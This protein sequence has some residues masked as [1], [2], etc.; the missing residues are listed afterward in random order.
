MFKLMLTSIAGFLISYGGYCLAQGPAPGKSESSAIM[1]DTTVKQYCVT[2]HNDT[3]KTAGLTLQQVDPY[4]IS[5]DGKIWEMVLRK[6]R[7]RTMPPAGMPRPDIATYDEVA[8]YL[9]TTLDRYAE[10]YP[11]PGRPSLRRLNRN[12]YLNA[13]RDLLAVKIND[14]T[15]LPSDDTMY[16]F[17]NVGAVLTLSPLLAEQYIT[18]AR[19]VRRQ[20]LGEPEMQPEFHSYTVPRYLM[21]ADWIGEDMPMGSR[22]GLALT[23]YFPMDG[24]YVVQIRLQRNSRDYIRG[25]LG[26]PHQI[27]IS[28]DKHK[29]GSMTVGG[30]KRGPSSGILSSATQGDPVQEA[31]E[32]HADEDLEIRFHAKAGTRQLVVTFPKRNVVAEEPL[33]TMQ[34]IVDYA[35]YKAGVPGIDIVTVG[36]PYNPQISH[37]SASRQKIFVCKPADQNDQAC[38]SQIISSLARR[39]YRRTLSDTEITGLMGFFRQGQQQGGFDEGIGHAIERILAG[40]RFLFVTEYV[41]ENTGAGELYRIPDV[42]LA[43]RLSLFLWSS[44]PDEELLALAESGQLANPEM[45]ANQVKRMLDDPRSRTLVDNFAS[46][47]LTLN[48]LNVAAPDNEIFP[49]FDDNLR[50]DMRRETVHFFEYIFRNNRPILELLDADYTFMNERLAQHYGIPDIYGNH[51]RKVTLGGE[52][53]GGLLGHGSILTVTSYANRTSPVTR[54]KWI[55]ENVL[56]APP[57]PPPAFVPG[58]REKND[59]GAVLSMRQ[60]MEQ[61][62]ANPVCASCHKVMDPLGFALENYDA[63]GRWRT[64]DAASGSPIDS[65][66]ALPD[67]TTFEGPVELRMTLSQKRQDDFVMTVVEK[68]LTY[69]LGR[70]IEYTDLPAIRSIMKDTESD[71]YRFS[72]LIM[73]VANSKPFQMRRAPGH[74]DI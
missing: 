62:R 37:D 15:I 16:G 71:D 59:E 42:E 64:V 45:L 1:L 5:A 20:A 11:Q 13:V 53:R 17:D 2:C 9:E 48:R 47:W 52:T 22:G 21:Q 32:R 14:D 6:F 39:A 69:A 63:I 36:G 65:T 74:D 41:P 30:E 54:G 46:Q 38:A 68:L 29:I 49:Y 35:Q 27:D 50:Q 12:E 73:A 31:Y 33:Y 61:H 58:L 28:L 19:F 67:G 44:I 60:Q 7:A 55:L 70:G 40:P 57:P 66:G 26:E 56:G 4:A 8:D 23:H 24:E 43:T 34:S 3:L 10:I 72:S 25:L 51:F 18:A